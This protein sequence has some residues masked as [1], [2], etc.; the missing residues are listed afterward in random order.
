VNTEFSA[1]AHWPGGF[2]E[3]KL[4]QWAENLRLQ[5]LAPQVSLGLVFMSPKFFPH[6][7]QTLEILRVH[8]RIPLL[9]GC[10]SPGL[11]ADSREIEN[12]PGFALALYSL[13]GAEL[14]GFRFTQKQVE[15]ADG[16]VYW[17]LETGIEPARTNG[18]LV[19][20]DP[21]HLDAESWIRSW[22]ESYA[23]L[24]ALGGLASGVFSDQTT[25]VYLNG[26]VFEDGGVAISVGGDVK[27]A[28]VISQGCTPIGETWTLTRV[29][30]NIIQQIANRPA[31][32]VLAETFQKLPPAEQQKA[33]GNLFIGLVVNEYLEDFHRGDF[34]VR[35]LIGGDLNSGVLAVGAMPRMGQTMQFQRRDAAAAIED[36]NE[37]IARAKNQLAGTTIYGGCLCCCN[38]RGQNFFGYPNHDA[39]LVQK[40]LGPIGLA[41]FFCNGE[42]G[43][44]G[45]KNFL[46][47]YT[48]SLALFVKK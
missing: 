16:A 36:M 11:I 25:Q 22:N 7:R 26:D 27:L 12:A 28:S 47:G 10:S 4:R 18:W 19:F 32:A 14:K 40:Q 42:I 33:R 38:G 3:V 23:P 35:N 24:P 34:L 8:A 15:E 46:H 13:P 45:E 5:L 21:F 1:A 44:V 20:I 48:A 39:E 30:H 43:P 6:A 9:A 2:D 37:L 17:R 41:G 31:Y 29:E